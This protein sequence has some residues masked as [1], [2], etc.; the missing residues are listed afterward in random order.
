MAPCSLKLTGMKVTSAEFVVGATSPSQFPR[1]GLPEIAFAG[2]SNVG[3]SSL[4]NRLLNRRNLA[5]VSKTPGRTQAINFFKI[6]HAFFFVD[7]PGYGYA[8]APKAL[9][10]SWG[11]LIEGYLSSQEALRAAVLIIDARHGPLEMDL[12]LKTFLDFYRIPAIIALTKTD[13]LP[14]NRWPYQV[15][16]TAHTFRLGSEQVPILFSAETGEGVKAIWASL[17]SSLKTVDSKRRTC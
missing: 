8:E 9:R 16:L 10:L 12:P 17:A 6:N 15:R 5:R 1:E 3:K 4:I 2:R 13:K 7:L 11:P 14:R